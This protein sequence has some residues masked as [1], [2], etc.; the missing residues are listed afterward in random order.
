[1]HIDPVSGAPLFVLDQMMMTG[2]VNNVYK[3]YG[4]HGIYY[5]VLFGWPGSPFAS[6]TSNEERDKLVFEEVYNRTY[7]D[8]IRKEE[9]APKSNDYFRDQ[10]TR[11]DMKKAIDVIAKLARVPVIEE[12][13]KIMGWIDGNSMAMDTKPHSANPLGA[14][15]HAEDQGKLMKTR[16]ELNNLLDEVLAKERD[17]LVKKDPLC[18]L[19]DYLH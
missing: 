6:I 18:S 4:I 12:K 15:K 16:K 9:I 3:R 13:N 11:A 17:L 2:A 8:M 5:A 10:Y 19:D 14:V 7:Y 1:M